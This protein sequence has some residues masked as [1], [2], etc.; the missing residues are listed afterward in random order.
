[1][2]CCHDSSNKTQLSNK[3]KIVEML[4]EGFFPIL[5]LTIT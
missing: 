1:M 2:N 4:N 5:D 3:Q